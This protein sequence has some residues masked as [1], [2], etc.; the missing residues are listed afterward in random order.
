M[1]ENRIHISNLKD[2][3]DE[4]KKCDMKKDL[5]KNIMIGCI[6]YDQQTNQSWR[7]E[8]NHWHYLSNENNCSDECVKK[9]K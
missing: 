3:F 4:I 9:D 8:N 6:H 1:E 7:F 5:E 2:D